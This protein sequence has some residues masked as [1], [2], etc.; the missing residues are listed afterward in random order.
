MAVVFLGLLF[1]QIMY[2]KN[3]AE[4]RYEQFTEGARKSMIAVAQ[5]LNRT[6]P[7]TFWKRMSVQLSHRR[8]MPS[9]PATRCPSS[10]A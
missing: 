4:M 7:A 5:G 2:M 10:A 3:M 1:M 9:I 6:K 8:C